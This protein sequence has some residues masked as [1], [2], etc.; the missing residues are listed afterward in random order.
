VAFNGKFFLSYASAQDR[1]HVWD[2]S[3]VR[4][5]GIAPGANAPTAAD[6]GA[7]AYA[8]TLRYYR[9]RWLMV[10]GAVTDKKS[11]PTPSVSFT[12]SG[13][14]AA[15]RV[16]QPTVPTNEGIT[17]WMVEAG[18]DNVTFFN[19][20]GNI[21]VATTT[22]DD[23]AAVTS[24]ADNTLSEPL[25]YF[26]LMPSLLAAVTD[27]NR[28]IGINGT[29][30]YWTPVLGSLDRGDDER[31]V[32][33]ATQN[34]YLD[35][36]G[37]GDLTAIARVVNG[38]I[39]VFR[40][41]ETWRLSPTGDA[42]KPYAARLL[43]PSVGA[44]NHKSV[45]V[46]EDETG[47]PVVYMFNTQ[48]LFRVNLPGTVEYCGRDAQGI[49][50]ETWTGGLR[51]K[52][53]LGG[54]GT[55]VASHI[56]YVRDYAQVYCFYAA[57][58]STPDNCIVFNVR[59]ATRR[60][61]WGV[62]GGWADYTGN[63]FSACVCSVEIRAL[64]GSTESDVSATRGADMRLWIGG[65]VGGTPTI[66]MTG[67]TNSSTD[68]TT[69]YQAFVTTRAII[70]GPLTG[71]WSVREATLLGSLNGTPTLAVSILPIHYFADQ[72]SAT[73]TATF[74][75]AVG[76][77]AWKFDDLSTGDIGPF[78]LRYGDNEAQSGRWAF[79]ALLLDVTPTGLR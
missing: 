36:G 14:G 52:I 53:D 32:D 19:I 46:G 51:S 44:L 2:G 18:T 49:T 58:A 68:D 73:V 60:D 25:G 65:A 16:T 31:I 76:S 67:R 62:R 33:T 35:L 64:G 45:A 48:G 17:H 56:T 41:S 75:P 47:N 4:R 54:V 59:R 9:V 6:T 43:H 30:V 74:V 12:P 78:R 11:E 27:G 42:V 15:A 20:S 61:F 23:S 22:Y 28:L 13:A 21:A 24:Y 71:R 39:F 37:S 55:V 10:T 79:E 38:I 8:A 69:P 26:T 66:Y 40:R 63:L 29:R 57:N 34:P 50:H 7:G 3:T 72:S 77:V 5:V 1:W 70:P